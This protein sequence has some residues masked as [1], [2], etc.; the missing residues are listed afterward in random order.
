[1][2]L[3]WGGVILIC[4]YCFFLYRGFFRSFS[5]DFDFVVVDGVFVM[6]SFYDEVVSGGLSVLGF[7]YLVF[8]G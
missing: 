8:V 3:V 1:M 7:G 2:V 6:F 4:W 5:S